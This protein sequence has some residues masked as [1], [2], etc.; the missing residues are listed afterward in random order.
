MSTISL[1]VAMGTNR[2]IGRDNQLPW[3]MPADM[4]RFRET[5][6]GKAVVMGRR[7]YN[8]IGKPLAGRHNIVL[9]RDGT[10]EA[11]G[12]TVVHS[13]AEA[14]EA[15]G[16]GEIMV[17]GGGLVYQQMLPLADRIY[18]TV[19]DGRFEGDSYFP[20]IDMAV[21][22]EISRELRAA[23]EDNPHDHAFIILERSR[24]EA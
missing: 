10:F 5:T 15:A 18:L 23:D 17:I 19:I 20:R 9:T 8:S 3:R 6:M 11:E 13:I 12:C 21:W 24:T 2:V 16:E 22:Q 14:L 1:I 7:T 4:R